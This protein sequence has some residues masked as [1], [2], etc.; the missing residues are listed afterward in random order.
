MRHKVVSFT[1]PY[2]ASLEQ[3]NPVVGNPEYNAVRMINKMVMAAAQ[4][5]KVTIFPELALNGYHAQDLFFNEMIMDRTEEAIE[6][7]RYAAR[8]LNIG[9][10]T[11]VACRN[12]EQYK[13]EKYLVNRLMIYIPEEKIDF[14]RNK[15]TLP[16]YQEFREYRYWEIGD[17]ADIRPVALKNIS[18]GALICEESWNNPA[19][20]PDPRERL[21]RH[22]PVEIIHSQTPLNV[23]INTSASPDWLGKDRIRHNMQSVVAR[24]YK[25]PQIFLNLVCGQ[26]E[27]LFM[28][29][30]FVMNSRGEM[31]AEMK[32]GKEDTLLLD[33]KNINNMQPLN[34]DISKP[35]SEDELMEHLDKMFRLYL[36]DYFYKSGLGKFEQETDLDINPYWFMDHQKAERI[37]RPYKDRPV[38]QPE[39]VI[40]LSGGVDSSLVATICARHLGPKNVKGIIMTYRENEYT[41]PE[42]IT[43][44]KELSGNLGIETVEIPVYENTIKFYQPYIGFEEGDL[45]HQNM[46][47]RLRMIIAWAVGNKENRVVMNTTNFTEAALGY[48]TIGG[49]LLGLPLIASLPKTLVRRYADWLSKQMSSM[50]REMIWRKPSAELAPDQFDENEL[51]EYDV[52]DPILESLRISR[53]NIKDALKRFYPVNGNTEEKKLF[54]DHFK[55]LAAKL[56]KGTEFKRNYYNRTPQ[57]TSFAWLRWIWPM[58]NGHFDIDRYIQEAVNEL[59]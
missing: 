18:L 30:S 23:N 16:D 49:D 20:F 4:G 1:E 34:I 40:G 21:Y 33:L 27:L 36:R 37:I 19:A 53:G 48:G 43:L 51:G 57:F 50:S 10:I 13:G 52:I 32:V 7:L 3:F 25:T 26:D 45:T 24:T 56:L 41:Q 28:G 22:D 2:L 14:T 29:K 17:P 39:V 47:A 6:M 54:I 8:Q 44:A 15:T 38:L 12:P 59:T 11:S 9:F 55:F 46:Q 58:A 5:A 35:Q 42:S 31:V